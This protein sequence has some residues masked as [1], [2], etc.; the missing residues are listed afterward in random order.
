MPA[1]SARARTI[2]LRRCSVI[3]LP[4]DVLGVELVLRG[5]VRDAF[6]VDAY[7]DFE[8]PVTRVRVRN[9]RADVVP[10]A[11]PAVRRVRCARV[12]LASNIPPRVVPREETHSL[13]QQVCRLFGV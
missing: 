13:R 5:D 9:E 3:A 11:R 6:A 12:V 1:T 4:L 10:R 2:T 8:P 7:A